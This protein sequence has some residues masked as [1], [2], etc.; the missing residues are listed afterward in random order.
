[1]WR[2]AIEQEKYGCGGW[3]KIGG[4]RTKQEM[5][6][7]RRGMRRRKAM[8]QRRCMYLEEG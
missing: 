8:E 6:G 2:K 7:S 1:M 5:Y 4:R 3:I